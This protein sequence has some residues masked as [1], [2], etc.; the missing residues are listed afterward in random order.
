MEKAKPRGS[1][2]VFDS[3]GAL[4]MKWLIVLICFWAGFVFAASPEHTVVHVAAAAR[5]ALT[6]VRILELARNV[7]KNSHTFLKS[8][9]CQEQISRFLDAVDKQQAYSLDKVTAKISFERGVEDYSEIYQN[10]ERRP[11]LSS[12]S[13]AWSEGEFGTLLLQTQKLLLTEHVHFEDFADLQGQEAAV[14]RFDVA[15]EDSP[16]DFIVAGRHYDLAFRTYVWIDVNTGEILK[17]KRKSVIIPP[18]TKIHEI[19]WSVQLKRVNVDGQSWLLPSGGDYSVSY[20]DSQ[21][22][23]WNE[24]SFSGYRKYGAEA[25]IRFE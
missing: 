23:E 20:A 13:G 4:K 6:D 3:K 11:S 15:S 24:F 5:K 1:E 12:I 19:Q 2:S 14:Y 17:I 9:V 18:Q 7:N 25:A 16:W 10:G 22:R 8:F 21:H